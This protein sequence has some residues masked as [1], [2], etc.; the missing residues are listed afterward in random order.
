MILNFKNI[1]FILYI[2]NEA[3]HPN[4]I[5]SIFKTNYNIKLKLDNGQMNKKKFNAFGPMNNLTLDELCKKI[6]NDNIK[7]NINIFDAF[8]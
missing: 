8:Y 2:S 4:T 1:Q 5:K 6:S 3:T 7:L